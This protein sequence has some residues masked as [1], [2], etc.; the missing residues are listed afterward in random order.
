MI[1]ELK[2]SFK[3]KIYTTLLY[4]PSGSGPL[5]KQLPFAIP[6]TCSGLM[7]K[8]ILIIDEEN[9][10]LGS[11]NFTPTSL[12]MH[13]NIVVGLH[14][15]E[16]ANFIQRAT[17]NHIECEV[18][19]QKVELWQLPD[20]QNQCLNYLLTSIKQA[21]HS[22]HL[23]L[24]TFTHPQILQELIEA[25]NRGVFISVAI[26]YYSSQGASKKAV[27]ILTSAQIIPKISR[28]GKLLHYKWGLIDEHTLF[29]G[30]A[31]WTQ[32]AFS[33]NEDCILVVHDLSKKQRIFFLK[34]WK[35]IE[36]NS[37]Q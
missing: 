25:K 1:H 11:A 35:N 33:K 22:I 20:F 13:D 3:K 34:I 10:F 17:S 28:P 19:A 36:L 30:S 4:D 32:S 15:K 14:T 37:L 27:E 12:R 24:F 9:L 18:G 5:Q 26:D 23:A 16:L 7:H 31:N 8:K 29:L 2:K 6:L 21:K